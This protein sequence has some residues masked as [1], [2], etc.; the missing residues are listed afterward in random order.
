MNNTTNY[1]YLAGYLESVIKNLAYDEKFRSFK[2]NDCEARENYL[3]GLIN[4][5]QAAARKFETAQS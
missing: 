3:R 4:E 5:A 2:K 1:P